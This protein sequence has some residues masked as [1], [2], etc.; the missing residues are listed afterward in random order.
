MTDE[1][2]SL[3]ALVE[4]S[5]DADLLREMIGFASQRLM[6]RRWMRWPARRV[7]R[8]IP[9]VWCSAMLNRP[10]FEEAPF[11]KRMEP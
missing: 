2:M 3:R 6:E 4:K 1:M 11:L 7:A 10:G 8:S 5:P 9:S